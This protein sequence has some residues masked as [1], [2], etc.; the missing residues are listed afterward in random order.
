MRDGEDGFTVP[1]RDARALADRLEQI[2]CDRELRERMSRSVKQRAQEL[3]WS[4]FGEL[5]LTA[6]RTAIRDDTRARQVS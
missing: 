5:L 1:F 3:N 6:T 2:I 4:H